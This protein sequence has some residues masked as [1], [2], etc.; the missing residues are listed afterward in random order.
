MKK[1]WTY[2]GTKKKKVCS[3]GVVRGISKLRRYLTGAIIK[4]KQ[5]QPYN[6]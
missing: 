2:D 6:H 1:E 3:I 5:K 4:P